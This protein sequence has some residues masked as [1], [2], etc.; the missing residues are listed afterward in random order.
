MLQIDEFMGSVCAGTRISRRTLAFDGQCY[1]VVDSTSSA[2]VIGIC[3]PSSTMARG[4]QFWDVKQGGCIGTPMRVVDTPLTKCL[5]YKNG[6]S[7]MQT[8]L[9]APSTSGAVICIRKI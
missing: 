1:L 8:C 3:S 7:M 2:Y 6:K 4:V 9:G 5:D